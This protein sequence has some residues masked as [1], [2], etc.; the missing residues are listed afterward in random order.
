MLLLCCYYAAI[1]VFWV[2]IGPISI[3]KY[4]Y[5]YI[6]NIQWFKGNVINYYKY[7]CIT[8]PLIF[9]MVDDNVK[10]ITLC[11]INIKRTFLRELT[12]FKIKKFKKKVLFK[13]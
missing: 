6:V 7:L 10:N 5:I 3:P 8:D 1:T 11:W 2:S 4:L 9:L 12:V 13:K